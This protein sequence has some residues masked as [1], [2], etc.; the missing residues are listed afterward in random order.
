MTTGPQDRMAGYV[1]ADLLAELD[2]SAGFLSDLI[3]AALEGGKIGGTLYGIP[4]SNKVVALYYNKSV[5]DAPPEDFDALLAAASEHGLALTL[6][7]F[8]NYMWVPAFGAQLFDDDLKAVLDTTGADEAFDFLKTVC[9]SDGVTCDGNDGDMDILYRSGEAAF[10]VQGPWMSGDAVKDLGAENVGVAR[11]PTI[12]GAGDPRPWNQSEVIQINVNASEAE[13]A[14]AMRFIEYLTS[15]DIQKMYMDKANWIPSNANVDIS[16]NPIVGGFAGQVP[17]SDPF[18]VVAEL[19]ATWA[20]MGD[21]VTKIIEGVLSPA[22]AIAE[23]TAL[24]NEANGK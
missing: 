16:G 7:W 24:I 5:V 22:D 12:P 15:A 4:I 10:R 9:E 20:P 23:A 13:V 18:P 8:H 1:D 21:A 6:D 14:A 3:P 19:G 17:F 11:V 2:T